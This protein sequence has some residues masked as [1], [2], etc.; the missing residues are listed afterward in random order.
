MSGTITKRGK[1]SW[2]IRFDAAA[3]NGKRQ[4]RHVTVRGSYADA[5]K[6]LTKLLA[7]RDAGILPSPTAAN[8]RRIFAVV[9]GHGDRA[10]AENARAIPRACGVADHPPPRR[11]PATKA[12]A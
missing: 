8:Y 1:N 12:R 4:R 5:R 2:A 6:E 11:C 10:L 3:L 7:A 9:A